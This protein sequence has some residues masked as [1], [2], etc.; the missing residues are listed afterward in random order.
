METWDRNE[1][2]EKVWSEPVTKVAAH[3][4]V[5]DVAVAKACRKLSVPMPGRG[6]WAKKAHGKPVP[7][8]PALPLMANVPV[9]FRSALPE[10]RVAARPATPAPPPFPAHEADIRD[11]NAIDGVF[12]QLEPAELLSDK[13]LRHPFVR[14]ARAI[15]SHAHTDRREMVRLPWDQACLDIRVSKQQLSRALRI[16]GAIIAAIERA[17]GS[18]H[19][20]RDVQT[21]V[22]EVLA[23]GE[24]IP[25]SI[26]ETARKHRLTEDELEHEKRRNKYLSQTFV[27]Q[28]TGVLSVE[29]SRYSRHFPTS[30]SD[31]EKCA[32]E[33][34][35]KTIAATMLKIGVEQRRETQEAL[36]ER[37]A[38]E[39]RQAELRE[40]KLAID[41][42]KERIQSLSAAA[43]RWIEAQHI[44]NFVAAFL[45]AK[46]SAGEST[47]TES[48]IGKWNEWALQQA[49]RIDPLRP[50][51]PSILDRES[52]LKE[53]APGP[54]W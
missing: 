2:Y 6:Y 37:R 52:E 41:K 1:L 44:R 25:F 38:H 27:Y 12:E 8:Q 23:F 54:S 31:R 46:S 22:A 13:T 43:R 10:L 50:N 33:E 36:E 9:V 34:Q 24:R 21:C 51:P 35:I 47:V 26:T 42:E 48:E 32:L 49:D 53:L 20:H 11:I 7:P 28:P 45:E 19:V 17:G 30:W 14:S 5:T 16:A 3:Y 4:G 29:V 40:L 15:L 18:V 39:R